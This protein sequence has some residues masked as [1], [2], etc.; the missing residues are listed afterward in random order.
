M[1]YHTAR[2]FYGGS[3]AALAVYAAVMLGVCNPSWEFKTFWD[4]G[5]LANF[6]VGMIASLPLAVMWPLTLVFNDEKED[7]MFNYVFF[8]IAFINSWHLITSFWISVVLMVASYAIET[9]EWYIAKI[10]EEKEEMVAE[11]DRIVWR[12]EQ[13]AAL[14]L[15]IIN[16]ALGGAATA[17]TYMNKVNLYNW[18]V[19]TFPGQ[20][21]KDDILQ[22]MNTEGEGN[23]IFDA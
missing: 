3:A 17:I 20:L 13:P 11:E 21:E 19:W 1:N 2:H 16:I 10:E 18:F 6:L 7:Y 12:E 22:E 8:F 15:M 9:R 14:W 23:P 5:V 4:A